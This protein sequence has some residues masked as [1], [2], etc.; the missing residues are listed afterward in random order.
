MHKS[1]KESKERDSKSSLGRED[2]LVLSIDRDGKIV[3][4]NKECKQT[5][6]YS[7][8]EILNRQFFDFLI[9]DR[10]LKP[11]K[12]TLNSVRKNKLIDDFRLPLLALVT[13]PVVLVLSPLRSFISRIRFFDVFELAGGLPLHLLPV[14]VEEMQRFFIDPNRRNSYRLIKDHLVLV[15]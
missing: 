8:D 11:W 7:K 5:S 2:S 6:G 9:P 15:F 4:F 14:L 12:N 13:E 3:K 10:Y 1:T